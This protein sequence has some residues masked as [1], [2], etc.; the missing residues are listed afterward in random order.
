MIDQRELGALFSGLRAGVTLADATGRIV[1]L[2]DRAIAHYKDRGGKRLVGTNL[3]DCHNPASQAKIRELYAR[4][5]AGD[6]TP[7]RYHE[8]K[9]NGSA[10][11]IVLIP[12]VVDGQF[13]GI[14]ELTW[15]ERP[16]LVFEA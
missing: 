15:D 9:G 6:L 5:R 2:N 10:K 16:E 7:T 8:D 1:F 12:I 4:H 13:R 14:A 3:N 11:G